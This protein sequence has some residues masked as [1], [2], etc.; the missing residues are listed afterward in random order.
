MFPGD[1]CDALAVLQVAPRVNR[2]LFASQSPNH[3]EVTEFKAHLCPMLQ[4]TVLTKFP[5]PQYELA[6][7]LL[8][9]A[10]V[11]SRRRL[12]LSIAGT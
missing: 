7:P 5:C 11:R 6:V 8:T 12:R 2:D 9:C 1:L 10:D 4:R 3:I